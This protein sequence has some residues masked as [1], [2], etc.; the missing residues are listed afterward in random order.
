MPV[1]DVQLDRVPTQVG[2]WS[3][4]SMEVNERVMRELNSDGLLLREYTRADELP[5]WVY[6]DYH[7]AQRLGA[8]IHSPITCYPGAGWSVRRIER[9]MVSIDG[10][11][12]PATWLTLADADGNTRLALYW[13]ETRWG[14]SA[15]EIDLKLDLLRSSIAQRPTD[16]VL[17]RLSSDAPE[18]DVAECR[19]RIVRLAEE[20]AAPIDGELP[21]S[22]DGA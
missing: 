11:D 18:G 22:Q 20:L 13:Y 9:G 15:R 10:R 17:V 2:E 3:S 12:R 21:F 6:V 8:Q 1:E 14:G 7:R 16:A 4:T 5:V 19:R